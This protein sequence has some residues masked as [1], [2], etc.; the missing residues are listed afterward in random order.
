MDRLRNKTQAMIN[1]GNLTL[2]EDVELDEYLKMNRRKP[3]PESEKRTPRK[4]KSVRL[5]EHKA[6]VAAQTGESNNKRRKREFDTPGV[7]LC[8]GCKKVVYDKKDL[9]YNTGKAHF[10]KEDLNRPYKETWHI[11]PQIANMSCPDC[12]HHWGIVR[13]KKR[14]EKSIAEIFTHNVDFKEV[15]SQLSNT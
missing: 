6:R 10:F 7:F 12:E 3:R 1:A 14:V 11:N 4:L 15:S 9:M 8:K 5:A 2:P 13:I